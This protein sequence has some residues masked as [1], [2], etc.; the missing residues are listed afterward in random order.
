L[1]VVSTLPLHPT[2]AIKTD[3]TLNDLGLDLDLR[4]EAGLVR[5]QLQTDLQSPDFA[6][7]GPLY[8]EHLNLA[9]ILS[10]P[11]QRSD[12]TG[13]VTIDL[14]LPSQPSTVPA[15]ERLGGT[16]AFKGP[17]AAAFGYQGTQVDAKGSF[18]GPSITLTSARANAYGGAATTRGTIV[19]PSGKRLI[20]YDLEGTTQHVDLRRLP[21]SL[22]V[23]KLETDIALTSYHVQG[24]GPVAR[25]SGVLGQSLVEGAT[26]GDGTTVQFETGHGPFSY[27]G[28]GTVDQFN[29]RRLGKALQIDVLDDPLYDGNVNGSFD[30]KASGTT[31]EELKL[32]S[33][34]TVRDSAMVGTHVSEMTFTADIADARLTTHATGG[35]DGLNPA[36]IFERR[37][38]DGNVNGRVD[39]TLTIADLAAPL[40]PASFAFEGQVTLDP[41]LVGGVQIVGG[42]ADGRYDAEVSD[43]KQLQLKGPDVTVDA[44][45]RLALDRASS[46]NLKYHIDAPAIAEV[47][48][49]AGQRGLQGSVQ[50]DGTITGNSAALHSD[51]TLHASGLVVTGIKALNLDTRFSADLPDFDVEKAR[52]DATSKATFLEIEDVQLN[53]VNATTK[54]AEKT[55]NFT[56][57]VQERTREVDATGTVIFHPDHQELHLPQ[58]AVRTEG[59]EWRNV[60]GS[61]AAIQYRQGQ[62]TVKDVKLASA[63]QTLDVSGTLE[64]QGAEKTGAIDVHARNVDIHQLEQLLLVDRGLTGR[65]TA[66]AKI[67]GTLSAPVVNGHAEITDGGFKNYRYQ[68]LI[69][70][71]GYDG[72]RINIAATLHQ[73]PEVSITANGIVPTSIFSPG[74]GEHVAP[75][76][77]DSI[78]LRI[79]TPSLNLGV[80][81]GFTTAV[82]N[83]AGTLQADVHV[84]GSGHDPHF[85]GYIE[86]RDGSFAVPRAGTTYSGLD[87][88]IDLQSDAVHIRR[89]EILD[90]DGEQMAVSGQLAVHEGGVGAVDISFES[91][92]FQLLRNELGA[93]GVGAKL[94]VTGELLRPKVEGDVRV[95][96]GRLELDQIIQLFYDPYRVEELPEVVSA[97]AAT[98]AAGSAEEATRKAL[99]QAGQT[100]NPE[101]QAEAKEAAAPTTGF[102]PVAL[103][104][105]VRM[106]DNLVL[107]GRRIRPGGPTRASLGDLN[108]T[109]GGELIIQK[110]PGHPVTYGGTITTVRGSYQFQGRQF[111]LARGG[112]IRLTGESELNPVLDVNATRQIPDTGIEAKIHITGSLKAPELTLSS[113]PPLEESDV[114]AL[115]IFNRPINELGT[116]ERASL[117]ATAGGIATGFLATPLGESIGKALDL[118]LF[119]ITTTSE[120]DTLGAGVTVGEQIGDR[121]FLKLRQ[122]FGERTLS[123]FLL[124]YRISDFLRFVGSAAPETSGAANRIGQRRIERA[125]VDL[126]FFFSY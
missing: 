41:S 114:L 6:F 33:S 117:A 90:D 39:G 18:K 40:T 23:P 25:G 107:R 37:A 28:A 20:A 34:G 49:L 38:L 125:G 104:I 42:F 94:K 88:R 108:I 96:S 77:A 68:S 56:T 47:G 11:A 81:Q 91:Q 118:D 1:R 16:F 111:D 57:T 31:L 113:T 8:L 36:V 30:V 67:S 32:S 121:T 50:I 78:D 46:S 93:I 24:N 9:N 97:G 2:F 14:K 7:A 10:N 48:L 12:I 61:E 44:S 5:G 51:G 72:P 60:Q 43:L 22:H 95:A 112:T 35:F 76:A 54:Y 119:E 100:A 83:V 82:T 110:A 120:G 71:V 126:I 123:E 109:V 75:T 45:G 101:R 58:F 17:H 27:G 115:I 63:D 102:D 55:L 87:T 3:G 122:Q 86:I 19:L 99:A 29:L 70:D 53:E 79:Q 65:L 124:E 80:V 92:N 105:H 66:D 13:N 98:Q 59:I 74:T 62:L 15:F 21:A 106:P 103:D 73:S 64:L 84:T 4:S 116:N 85:E 69:A 89:F 52:V 26:V